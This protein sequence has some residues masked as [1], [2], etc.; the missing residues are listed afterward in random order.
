MKIGK[1]KMDVEE[2]KEKHG[3]LL[4]QERKDHIQS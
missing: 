1:K 3:E 4:H 2:R